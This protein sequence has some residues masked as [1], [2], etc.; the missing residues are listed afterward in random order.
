MLIRSEKPG[1][2]GGSADAVNP[3]AIPAASMPI[4]LIGG[5]LLL[6]GP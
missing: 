6:I 5:L 1:M 2:T 3:G 4:L